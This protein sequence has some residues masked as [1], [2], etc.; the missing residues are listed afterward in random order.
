MAE[1]YQDEKPEKQTSG[2]EGCLSGINKAINGTF[3]RIFDGLGRFIARRP[4]VV[5]ALSAI[6]FLGIGSGFLRL[7]NETR[8][9]SDAA[10]CLAKPHASCVCGSSS[11]PL[12]AS[13]GCT[14]LVCLVPTAPQ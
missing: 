2:R 7:E 4:I 10:S 5:I 11:V 14:S 3:E 13:T 12:H 9:T 6:I 8:Y 1:G